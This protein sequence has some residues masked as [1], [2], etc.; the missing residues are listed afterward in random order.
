MICLGGWGHRRLRYRSSWC[1]HVR[2]GGGYREG[3]WRIRDHTVRDAGGGVTRTLDIT[4]TYPGWAR[5][6]KV[7][8]VFLFFCWPLAVGEH[9]DGSASLL[10]WVLFFAWALC[11]AL[12][13]LAAR[14]GSR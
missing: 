10:G 11:A 12:I 5:F 6:G 4:R 2:R 3:S 7:A 14:C 8:G 1:V 9:A 13:W